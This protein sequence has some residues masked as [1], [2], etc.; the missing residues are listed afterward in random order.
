MSVDYQSIF[1]GLADAAKAKALEDQPIIT[2]GE[3]IAKL[4]QQ[5]QSASLAVQFRGMLCALDDI[6][7]YRG[8]YSDLC[9]EPGD[10]RFGTVATALADLRESVGR[11]FTGYKGGEYKM[12]NR[13]IVWVDYYGACSGVG[14]TG[15]QV[16]SE[17]VVVITSAECEAS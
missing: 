2:L 7:S 17:G 5:D 12:T 11:T 16:N 10:D 3:L 1:S 4:E 6:S 8:Y 15:V 14:V 9:L 13:T